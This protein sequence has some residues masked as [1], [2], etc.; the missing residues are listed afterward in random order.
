M[1]KIFCLLA[2]I[3]FCL[4]VGKVWYWRTNGFSVSRLH[5]WTQTLE[6]VWWD[7]EA[8]SVIA[9]DFHYLG[10]G[11]QAFAFVSEDGKYVIKFPRGDIFKI[12][13]W[14]RALPFE[15]RRQ[16]Q[17]MRKT[18]RE[19]CVLQSARL[20][21]EELK[22]ATAL[23]AMNFSPNAQHEKL[24]NKSVRII[25][26]AG[27]SL[28]IPLCTTYFILQRKKR[29]FQDVIEE[30]AAK[31]GLIGVEKVLDDLFAN[32]LERTRKGI[33][34]RDG[35]FLRNYGFDE[36]GA[37]QTDV[38]SF[39]KVENE[40]M[41]AVYLRSMELSVRPIRRWMKKKH[42]KWVE[43]LDRKRELVLN[44]GPQSSNRTPDSVSWTFHADDV[45]SKNS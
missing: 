20:A 41:Q 5:G 35:S 7:E 14:L 44:L 28:H 33:L 31:E 43:I 17:I 18:A 36:K 12:P 23:I 13:F 4:G 25:D 32:I 34:N 8:E 27:R 16:R 1:R 37:Y 40:S 29:L 21:M 11:R 30:A 38:G 6:G 3:G 24:Q 26:Q 22:D 9:Q 10:R 39:Y 45:R 2:L 19:Q 42:P 15:Q